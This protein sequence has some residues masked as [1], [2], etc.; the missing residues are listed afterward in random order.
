MLDYSCAGAGRKAV[1]VSI[2]IEV[3]SDLAIEI[4]RP[5]PRGNSRFVYC[6]DLDGAMRIIRFLLK[7]DLEKA[8]R[9]RF[10]PQSVKEAKQAY[11]TLEQRS[12]YNGKKEAK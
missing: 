8:Q 10:V 3:Q 12:P 7:R 4:Q 9:Q 2:R 5:D 6:Q 11:K 1:F